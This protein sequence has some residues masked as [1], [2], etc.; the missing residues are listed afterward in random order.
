MSSINKNFGDDDNYGDTQNID[1]IDREAVFEAG[2]S[3]AHEIF[4]DKTDEKIVDGMVDSAIDKAIAQGGDTQVAIGILKSMFTH[5]FGK[6]SFRNICKVLK[7]FAGQNRER[8]DYESGPDTSD[9]P[10]L[11]LTREEII[12][13]KDLSKLGNLFKSK[14]ALVNA[15][16]DS[17]F[18]SELETAFPNNDK[19]KGYADKI[20]LLAKSSYEDLEKQGENKVAEAART[21]K[22][23]ENQ[24]SL[25]SAIAAGAESPGKEMFEAL[26]NW[27]ANMRRGKLGEK[28]RE[29]DDS[30]DADLLNDPAIAD[31]V[32][33]SNDPELKKQFD[34][35][36]E[37]AN[38]K[39]DKVNEKYKEAAKI[40]VSDKAG[41]MKLA[42]ALC[43]INHPNDYDQS[44]VKSMVDDL[45]KELG[46]TPGVVAQR[47]KLACGAYR[48]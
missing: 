9:T 4:G 18:L 25:V 41:C 31:A 12:R 37:Q 33:S 21:M 46:E 8:D 15:A 23:I 22:S 11:Q 13:N 28:M 27:V 3:I 45:W 36:K 47:I 7:N 39:A 44:I 42:E 16:K 6:S 20:K 43:K 40:K 24:K 30:V 29:Y 14:R 2:M 26:M 10:R 48:N 38:A 35:N 32:E 5:N 19:G 17:A 1:N 34:D